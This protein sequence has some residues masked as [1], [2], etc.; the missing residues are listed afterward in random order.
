MMLHR[1]TAAFVVPILLI[2]VGVILLLNT[3][4]IVSWTSWSEIGRFWPV[5]VIAL[6]LSILW[7]NL[8][9]R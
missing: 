5:L 6:G 1:S 3:L 9:L 4:G 2:C 7:K 8:R